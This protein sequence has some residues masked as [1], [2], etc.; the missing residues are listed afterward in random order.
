MK[1]DNFIKVK[2]GFVEAFIDPSEISHILIRRTPHKRELEISMK[3][4]QTVNADENM[5]VAELEKLDKE[6][7]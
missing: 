5:F 6:K 1:I 2:S 4:G 3:N 7:K